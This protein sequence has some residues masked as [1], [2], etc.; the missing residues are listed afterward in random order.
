MPG[1]WKCSSS[2]FLKKKY[3]FLLAVF[4]FFISDVIYMWCSFHVYADRLCTD[5]LSEAFSANI[6]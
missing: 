1:E 3:L 2:M 6:I 5:M 4:L